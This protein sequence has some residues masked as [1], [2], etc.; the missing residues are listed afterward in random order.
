L[1]RQTGYTALDAMR[2]AIAESDTS[3]VEVMPLALDGGGSAEQVRR[4][5]QKALR[6]PSVAALVG[7]FDPSAASAVDDVLAADG[8]PW[9][10]PHT[11]I[12]TD[13]ITGIADH[14]DPSQNL[15]LAGDDDLLAL[16]NAQTLAA[17]LDRPLR[18]DIAPAAASNQDT[19][20][21]LGG[22]STAADYLV[23]M[24][25]HAPDAPFWLAFNGD[26]PIFAQRVLRTPGPDGEVVLLGPVYWTVWLED[27]YASWAETHAPNTPTAYVTYRATQHA[28]AQITGADIVTQTQHLHIFQLQ[29]DGSS[30]LS[31]KHFPM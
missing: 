8:R 14:I 10:A 16:V 31:E 9:Y 21:W 11:Q 22:A 3:G 2:A 5:T 17:R 6:D 15:L 28:I 30:T 13:T 12:L 26:T 19:V 20:I 7:P 18:V 4:A 25:V 27:G 24:R 1:Y 23:A 29:P